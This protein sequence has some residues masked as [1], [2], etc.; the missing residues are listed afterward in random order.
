MNKTP[1]KE[2]VEIAV[3]MVVSQGAFA[4]MIFTDRLF[5]SQISP[6]HMAASLG[7]GVASFLCL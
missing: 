1:L 2:L 4:V 6:T 7:G 3:P 5:M